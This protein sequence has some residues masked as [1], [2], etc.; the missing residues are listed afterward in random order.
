[1]MLLSEVWWSDPGW[2]LAIAIS[3]IGSGII[4]LL[5]YRKQRARKQMTFQVLSDAPTVNID[6]R[7]EDKVKILYLDDDSSYEINDANIVS[8]KVWNSGEKD[9]K[10]W[11]AEDQDVEDLEVPIRFMFEGRTVVSLTEVETDPPE[12]VI[13]SKDLEKY[14]VQPS[15]TSDSI[16]LPRC[17]LKP[18]QSISLSLLVKGSKGEIYTKGKLYQGKI[19]KFDLYGEPATVRIFSSPVIPL[20]FVIV[21]VLGVLYYVVPGPFKG[22][23]S[24]SLTVAAGFTFLF[25][26]IILVGALIFGTFNFIIK[27]TILMRDIIQGKKK[28]KWW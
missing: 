2:W 8:L 22:N 20:G 4:A 16:A 15:P 23:I 27:R 10:V 26:F 3:T 17:L 21:C 14:L 12:K 7:V 13:E 24:Y 25:G 11:N 9:V 19:T 6:K 1:M 18:G 28:L 5:I